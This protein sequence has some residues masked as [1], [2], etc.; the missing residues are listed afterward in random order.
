MSDELRDSSQDDCADE[1]DDGEKG[2]NLSGGC[3]CEND[4]EDDDDVGEAESAKGKDEFGSDRDFEVFCD[5]DDDE[6]ER[7][8]FRVRV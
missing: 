4:L 7:L 5:D 8:C 2:F 3:C 1:L 6:E